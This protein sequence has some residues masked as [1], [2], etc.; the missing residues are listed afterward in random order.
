M[1]ANSVRLRVV[2]ATRLAAAGDLARMRTRRAGRHPRVRGHHVECQK[3]T[4]QTSWRRCRLVAGR[5]Q[6]PP[7]VRR[8]SDMS[9]PCTTTSPRAATPVARRARVGHGE[10]SAWLRSTCAC[11][12]GPA[13]QRPHVRSRK[14]APPRYG[15]GETKAMARGARKAALKCGQVISG[16]RDRVA[17]RAAAWMQ[18]TIGCICGRDVAPPRRRLATPRAGG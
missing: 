8:S 6:S 5:P 7:R 10:M 14:P 3:P 11:A 16:A 13:M 1:T 2:D 4:R 17:T 18:S 9:A 12:R 15:H